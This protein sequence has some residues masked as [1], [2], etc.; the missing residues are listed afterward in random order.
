MIHIIFGGPGKGKS[1]KQVHFAKELCQKSGRALLADC[2][3]R[4]NR[5]RSEGYALNAPDRP[6]IFSDFPM[7]FRTGYE[8]WFETYY[9]N[10]YYLGLPNESQDVMYVPPGSVIFLS[11]AQ[12]YYY[13]R[14][15]NSFP[16][17]VSRFYEMHR[18]YGLEIYMDVQRPGLIDANIRELCEHFIEIRELTHERNFAG[19][20]MSS[21]W[22]CREWD[23]W[24]RVEQYLNTDVKNYEEREYTNKGDIFSNY[25][26]FTYF[27]NFLPKAGGFTYL[28]FE[29]SEDYAKFYSPTEPKTYRGGKAS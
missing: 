9:V 27:D 23:N 8:T 21:T 6:P 15:S 10:G 1:C 19:R 2:A 11:E 25:D 16:E 17:W 20:I 7:R 22:K 3:A 14:K 12:R 28:P 29:A 24:K 26:S 5:A 18:H 13:S 4:I